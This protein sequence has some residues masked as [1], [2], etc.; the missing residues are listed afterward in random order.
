MKAVKKVLLAVL[1]ASALGTAHA[2]TLVADSVADFSGTQGLNSWFYGYENGSLSNYTAG[3]FTQFS[4]FD[5]IAWHASSTFN[6]PWTQLWATGGH[7]NTWNGL[8]QLAV[9]RWVSETTGAVTITGTLADTHPGGNGVAGSIYVDGSLVWNGDIGSSGSTNFSFS[10]LVSQNSKV[11]FVLD[12]KGNDGTDSSR[13]SA[14]I[15]AAVPEPETYAML[16]AGLGVL[17][18]VVRRRR[19]KQAA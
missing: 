4:Y 13:F 16:M 18:T 17:G 11:D 19:M 5:G 10:T 14:T 2:D 15:A 6:P 3:G 12:A 7:P 8:Q 1:A 9:R